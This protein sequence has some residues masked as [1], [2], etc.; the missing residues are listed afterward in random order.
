MC[1]KNQ[2]MWM[3]QSHLKDFVASTYSDLSEHSLHVRYTISEKEKSQLRQWNIVII[4]CLISNWKYSFIRK[5]KYC[6]QSHCEP[7][8]FH[9]VRYR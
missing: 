2:D 4:I 9:M 8:E 3:Q 5:I 7:N 1:E 6:F